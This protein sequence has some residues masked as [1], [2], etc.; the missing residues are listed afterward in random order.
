M[1]S[2]RQILPRSRRA[3]RAREMATTMWEGNPANAQWISYSANQQMRTD[4]LL[5]SFVTKR[6]FIHILKFFS[7]SSSNIIV[8]RVGFLKIQQIRVTTTKL[9]YKTILKA[10]LLSY[11]HFLVTST[12][13]PRQPLICFVTAFCLLQTVLYMESYSM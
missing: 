8:T 10:Q 5:L 4:A 6:K 9:E 2:C 12:S 13:Q 3:C 1:G 11:L 7:Q